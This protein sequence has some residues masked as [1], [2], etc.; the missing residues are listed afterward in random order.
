MSPPSDQSVPMMMP[1][2][3][4]IQL[5]RTPHVG[6]SGVCWM[7]KETRAF[8]SPCNLPGNRICV[9]YSSFSVLYAGLSWVT[10]NEGITTFRWQRASTWSALNQLVRFVV[11]RRSKYQ[12]HA[13]GEHNSYGCGLEVA[14]VGLKLRLIDNQSISISWDKQKT[15][16]YWKFE[17]SKAVKHK[18]TT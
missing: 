16:M 12:C 13:Q 14:R 5:K 2:S 3:L 6:A 1:K 18:I 4:W 17:I 11:S 7:L 10:W 15:D 8:A 9:F